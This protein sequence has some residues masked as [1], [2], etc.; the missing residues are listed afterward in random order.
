MEEEPPEHR[1]T[2]GRGSTPIIP[3]EA[4]KA[5]NAH[6]VKGLCHVKL[7]KN[8]RAIN[9]CTVLGHMFHN[10]QRFGKAK[11]VS[12]ATWQVAP[13]ALQTLRHKQSRESPRHDEH[14]QS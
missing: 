6:G 7:D 12:H 14:K 4:E 11:S 5:T 1:R 8:R 9:T 2:L 3:H 10:V 13:Q